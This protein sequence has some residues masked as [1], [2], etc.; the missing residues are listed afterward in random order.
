MKTKHATETTTTVRVLRSFTTILVVSG[1][2]LSL[3]CADNGSPTKAERTD[4]PL[5]IGLLFDYTGSLGHLGVSA[6]EGARF[7]VELV[8]EAGGVAGHKVELVIEDGETHPGVA[9]EAARRLVVD[10]G[11]SAIIGPFGSASALVVAGEVTIEAKVPI[12]SPSATAPQLTLFVDDGYVFRNCLSDAAQG[13]ALALVV[14]GQG[15]DKVAILYRNDPYGIGLNESFAEAFPGEITAAVPIEPDQESYI[16]ELREAAAASPDAL[17]TMA[18]ATDGAVFMREALG[19]EL[20]PMYFLSDAMGLPILFSSVPA[21]RLEGTRGTATRGGGGVSAD[22]IQVW[23]SEFEKYLGHPPTTMA[24]AT[25]DAVLG[26]CLAAER[27]GSTSSI[28][29]RDLLPVVTGADGELTVAID[30]A[31]V[32]SAMAMVR[33]GREIDY[34]GLSSSMDLTENGDLATGSVQVFEI[35]NGQ[36]NVVDELPIVV[37]GFS[38][39]KPSIEERE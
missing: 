14:S 22:L 38:P 23:S 6:E 17:I 4:G 31:G 25:Y 19:H 30:A 20:F 15:I 2:A 34:Q 29:I 7:A 5:R 24:Q 39:S 35:Q 8:N 32:E 27:A 33:S 26:V 3:A 9:V 10:N 36:F 28:S 18:F 21:E 11:V 37:N 16:E 1:L 12:I 13:P